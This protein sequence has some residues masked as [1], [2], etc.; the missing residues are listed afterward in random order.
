MPNI[1]FNFHLSVVQNTFAIFAWICFTNRSF[2]V[3][4]HTVRASVIWLG[5]IT[6]SLTLHHSSTSTFS[7]TRAPLTPATPFTIYCCFKM[8][9]ST[10]FNS[11]KMELKKK[12][13]ENMIHRRLNDHFHE[14]ILPCILAIQMFCTN[15]LISLQLK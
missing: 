3:R 7:G 1:F 11:C 8:E 12:V 6:K 10:I 14:Y 9:I 13:Y 5:I 2:V 15:I 4:T